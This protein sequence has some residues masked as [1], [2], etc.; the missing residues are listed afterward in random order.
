MIMNKQA[1]FCDGTGVYVIPPEPVEDQKI[2]LR[3]R[4]AKDDVQEAKVVTRE[5]CYSDEEGSDKG[6]TIFMQKEQ[7][8]DVFDYYNVKVQIG[9]EALRYYFEIKGTDGETIYYN[10]YGAV[11]EPDRKSVV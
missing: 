10:R 2:I 11:S 6:K 9:T 8:T 3:F 1:L 4:T 7:T 5:T